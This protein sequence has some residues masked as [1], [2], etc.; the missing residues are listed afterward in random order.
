MPLSG[1][2]IGH[3][4]V[5][6]YL[7]HLQNNNGGRTLTPAQLAAHFKIKKHISSFYLV[8]NRGATINNVIPRRHLREFRPNFVIIDIGSNDLAKPNSEPL[9][10]ASAIVDLAN[11]CFLTTMF[12]T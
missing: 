3:S 9:N 4:F 12:N 7:H 5:A 1:M 11:S 10:I 8:G 6:G 2:V